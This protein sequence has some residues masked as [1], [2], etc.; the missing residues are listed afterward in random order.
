[1]KKLSGGEI[2]SFA[3]EICDILKEVPLY[4]VREVLELALEFRDREGDIQDVDTTSSSD[5]DD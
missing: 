1:M 2:D 3:D 5:E 4:Y